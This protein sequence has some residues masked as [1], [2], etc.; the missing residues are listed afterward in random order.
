MKQAVAEGRYVWKAPL[1]YSNVRVDGK[2]T[3]A[4]NNNAYIVQDAFDYFLNQN[5]SVHAVLRFVTSKYNI[6]LSRSRI[7]TLLKNP[8]YVGKI[9]KFGYIVDGS[10]SGIIS[11]QKFNQVQE[12]LS[13][14]K[15]RRAYKIVNPDFPLRRFIK[16]NTGKAI[17]GC[18]CK[19]NRRKYAYYRLPNN[20]KMYSKG[21]IES[22]FIHHLNSYGINENH[23]EHFETLVKSLVV[24]KANEV[25]RN[26]DTIAQQKQKLVTKRKELITKNLDGFIDDEILK[27]QLTI[28]N[29]RINQI[30]FELQKQEEQVDAKLILAFAKL[31]LTNPGEYWKSLSPQGKELFQWFA[32]PAGIHFDENFFQTTKIA[33]I[34]KVK[35]LFSDALYCLVNQPKQEIKQLDQKIDAQSFVKLIQ[36]IHSEFLLY[37]DRKNSSMLQEK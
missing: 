3:I 9:D 1:G 34:F 36:D 10:F 13:N 32:F 18:W 2:S 27:E 7:Y 22:L 4:P 23:F 26:K 33:S 8:I 14:K 11:I 20:G 21:E 28:C 6:K 16:T 17:T 19:G 5:C 37:A 25:E 29:E 15:K 31:F 30:E 24:A 12:K 35:S